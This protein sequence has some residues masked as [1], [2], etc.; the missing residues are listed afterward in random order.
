M[1]DGT[2]T[3]G[4]ITAKYTELTGVNYNEV[5]GVSY[6]TKSATATVNTAGSSWAPAGSV[7]VT[8]TS[9][10]GETTSINSAPATVITS[11]NAGSYSTLTANISGE[12]LEYS[13]VEGTLPT[14]GSITTTPTTVLTSNPTVGVSSATFTGES[15]DI[16]VNVPDTFTVDTQHTGAT[17]LTAE[18]NVSSG[19]ITGGTVT[20]TVT[21]TVGATFT[22]TGVNLVFSG[23]NSDI[24][25]QS[26]QIPTAATFTGTSANIETNAFNLPTSATFTGTEGNVEVSGTP[27]GTIDATF[28]GTSAVLSGYPVQQ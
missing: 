22:G 12:T 17:I 4:T 7:D 1:T 23:E 20:G 8:L 13:L 14:A 25:V 21:G 2:I 15:V 16:N 11:F 5:T 28:N 3:G 19:A 9:T 18:S 6:L 26:D 10:A 24:T 27:T